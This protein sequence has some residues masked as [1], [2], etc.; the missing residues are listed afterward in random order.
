M[1]RKILI[2]LHDSSL[3]YLSDIVKLKGGDE[4]DH[5]G[6]MRCFAKN[7]PANGN[8]GYLTYLALSTCLLSSC[9]RLRTPSVSKGLK[10]V[11]W[12]RVKK[13]YSSN[14][15]NLVIIIN[16]CSLCYHDLKVFQEGELLLGWVLLFG[17]IRY[18][19]FG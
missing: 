10:F 13:K 11:V 1:S 19:V 4:L 7:T 2:L 15:S 12:E 17:G 3:L 9:C 8:S 18:S 6:H 16:K 5:I 14:S